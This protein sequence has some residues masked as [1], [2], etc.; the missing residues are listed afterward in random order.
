MIIQTELKKFSHRTQLGEF[1]NSRGFTGK[2]VEVG[3][4]FGAHATDILKTWK[5]HLHCVDPWQNQPESV[6]F[7]GANKH[8][9]NSVFA[10]VCASLGRNPKCTLLRMMSLNA[11]GMFDDGE[12]DFVY[13]DGNHGL[14]HIRAD[15]AAW[16]PK[17][18]IGGL[19]CGHDY[20]TRYD[21]DTDSDA[22]TAVAELSEAL[23]I[24]VHVTWDTSWWFI[25]TQEADDAL[26]RADLD[27]L[28]PR[29]IYSDNRKTVRGMAIVLPIARFDWNLAVKWLTWFNLIEPTNKRPVIAYCSPD[30]KEAEL[31]ALRN[32]KVAG[33]KV[34]VGEHKEIGYFGTPN[35][36]IKGALTWM[37]GNLHGWATLWC[38]ADTVAM[39]PGWADRI[40]EEY[41]G[42]GRPFMGDIYRGAGAVPHMTGN[43]VYHPKWRMFAPSLAALGTEECGWDTLCAHDT[44]P[45]AHASKTIQQVWRPPLPI[46]GNWVTENVRKEAMLFHQCKDGSLID[47]LCNRNGI[48]CIPLADALCKSTYETQKNTIPAVTGP[49]MSIGPASALSA[50]TP[51]A[52]PGHVEIFYVSFGR[53]IGFLKYSLQSAKKYAKGFGGITVA[54]PESERGLYAWVKNAKVVYFNEEHGKG[55]LHQQIIKC[56][57]DGFCPEAA[58]ILHMDADTMFWRDCSPADFFRDGK[59]I[60]VRE[61]YADLRNPNRLHWQ[62]AVEVCAGF[63]PEYE[64]MVRQGALHIREVYAKARRMVEAH[65]GKSFDEYVLSCSPNFPQTFAE[66]PLLGAVA[67]RNFRDRYTCEDYDWRRDARECGIPESTSFQFIYRK[68][69]DPIV[70]FWSHGGI[71]RY[72]SDMDAIMAGRAPAH[73]VK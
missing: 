53:D 2:G 56:R 27:G 22:G 6:Y 52:I 18:K 30:L 58:C 36:V 32:T 57:A 40:E 20:F 37:V 12:L 73:Y 70:E 25:K 31:S 14:D 39:A 69:R 54:V 8:D 15:I 63:K 17:V 43:A 41:M 1:L 55:M 47:V 60:L 65:V 23:G 9:M 72:K 50:A 67:I 61:R 66:F 64:T 62:R 33:L 45:R 42:C 49:S 5:G 71:D 16:W 68:Q 19:V 10:Q 44:L 3:T 28:L 24:R 26:K 4:L 11:V 21:N 34:V 7:D 29:P 51:S 38:E 48:P 46:T 59:P 13:L 35:Q